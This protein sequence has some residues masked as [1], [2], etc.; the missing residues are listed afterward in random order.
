MVYEYQCQNARCKTIIEVFEKA[1]DKKY[2]ED[3]CPDCKSA[4]KRII[5][6]NTFHLKGGGWESKSPIGNDFNPEDD[7]LIDQVASRKKIT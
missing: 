1:N 2:H 4:M 5:S 3:L 6:K 7:R